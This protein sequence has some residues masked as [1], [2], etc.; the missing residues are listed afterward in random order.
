MDLPLQSISKLVSGTVT[1]IASLFAN[2]VVVNA[3][4]II[5]TAYEKETEGPRKL[6]AA[7]A[8]LTYKD[9]IGNVYDT[10]TGRLLRNEKPALSREAIADAQAAADEGRRRSAAAAAAG[11]EQ[12]VKLPEYIPKETLR[13]WLIT[14]GFGRTTGDYTNRFIVTGKQI[15][16]ASCRERV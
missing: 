6:L 1:Q 10:A 8:P 15:G 7:G 5:G 3:L 14:K 12:K 16:R 9:D 13:N 11:K 4:K 2:P